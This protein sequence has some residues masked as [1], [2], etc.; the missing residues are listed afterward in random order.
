MLLGP[1][2]LH[3]LHMLHRAAVDNLSL[4]CRAEVTVSISNQPEVLAIYP[5][6]EYWGVQIKYEWQV[7]HQL[8]A[9]AC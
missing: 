4:S 2:L 8:S 9:P 6:A 7:V 3:L 5:F 1:L